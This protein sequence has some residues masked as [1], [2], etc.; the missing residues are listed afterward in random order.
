MS[1]VKAA[2]VIILLGAVLLTLRVGV[3]PAQL[4]PDLEQALNE[5]ALASLKAAHNVIVDG[6][7]PT[8]GLVARLN[9]WSRTYLSGDEYLNNTLRMREKELERGVHCTGVEVTLVPS[10]VER[11]GNKVKLHARDRFTEHREF[12]V[13]VPPGFPTESGGVTNHDFVFSVAPVSGP[14]PGPFSVEVRGT[15]YTL[16]LDVNEPQLLQSR[17]SSTYCCDPDE[18]RYGSG[19]ASH[20]LKDKPGKP[21]EQ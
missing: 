11:R 4:P 2:S 14:R 20:P 1:I 18:Q 19:K 3:R 5:E 9:A 16:I 15:V 17:D 13:P 21:H 12:D 7:R 6:K 10:G 8:D